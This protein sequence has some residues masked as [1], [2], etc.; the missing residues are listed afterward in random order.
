MKLVSALS[1]IAK[2]AGKAQERGTQL[3]VELRLLDEKN[4]EH[5][6]RIDFVDNVIDTGSGTI[7]GRAEFA[8]PNSLFTPGMFGR[9]RVPGS[10]RYNALLVP[11]AAIGTEQSARLR[12]DAENTRQKYIEVARCRDRR[13]CSG[14]EETIAWWSTGLCARARAV[15]PLTEEQKAAITAAM[16]T[17]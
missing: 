5:K 7:R 4:F 1:G 2:E 13:S 8:N 16:A 9:L 14:L 11:D 6:G 10:P 15:T 17:A 3:P 12:V